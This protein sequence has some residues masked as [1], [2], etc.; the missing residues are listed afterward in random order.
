MKDKLLIIFFIISI[1]SQQ[2]TYLKM[3]EGANKL[4][5]SLLNNLF[6]KAISND[7]KKLSNEQLENY[8]KDYEIE[9]I[10]LFKANSILEEKKKE[11]EKEEAEMQLK[12]YNDLKRSN[13][14]GSFDQNSLINQLLKGLNLD[15]KENTSIILKS[16]KGS[17]SKNIKS[18]HPFKNNN[19]INIKRLDN[20]FKK[21]NY[22]DF[23][24]FDESSKKENYFEIL[25]ES[26]EKNNYIDF[27]RPENLSLTSFEKDLEKTGIESSIPIAKLI[28]Q[29]LNNYRLENNL[30]ILK[31]DQEVY[32]I[33]KKQSIY[34]EKKDK[35]SHDNFTKRMGGNYFSANENVG[36]FGGIILKKELI[37][38]KLMEMWKDSKGH[39]KNMKAGNVNAG[40]VHVL[41]NYDTK[42]YFSTMI[43]VEI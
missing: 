26:S 33:S 37:A 43:L 11:E 16:E 35:L 6:S 21:N 34:M 2:M 9:L 27:P 22:N 31:W 25:D 32:E 36:M 14:E 10:N 24:K 13:N 20:P 29:M 12:N 39:D 17:I 19:Y 42:K 30:K 28:F 41:V 5:N 3:F 38:R 18:L 8:F 4:N 40:A 7:S 23:K 15:R 1:T